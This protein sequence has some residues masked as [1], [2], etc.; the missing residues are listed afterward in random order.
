MDIIVTLL[1]AVASNYQLRIYNAGTL[2]IWENFIEIF[3]Q[4]Y[5]KVKSKESYPRKKPWRPI[6]V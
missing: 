4:Q 6:G 5:K 1:R 2:S 3:I